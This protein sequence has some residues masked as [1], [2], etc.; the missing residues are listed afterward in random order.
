MK[1]LIDT[2]AFLWLI[3]GDSRLSA[4][5]REAFLEPAHQLYLS[6]SSL[7]EISIKLSLGKL[8]LKKGWLK[9][10]ETE[11]KRNLVLLLPIEMHHC[12]RLTTL[13]FHHRDPFDRMLIAQAAAEGMH[14]LSSDSAFSKYGTRCIW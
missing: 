13:P 8:K 14:I 12:E 2:H 3:T 7:W 4:G 10:I 6:A 5:A 9:I 1:I 11:M